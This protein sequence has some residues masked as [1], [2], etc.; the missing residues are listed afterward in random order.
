MSA[1]GDMDIEQ[2][3]LSPEAAK[4]QVS[5]ITSSGYDFLP[6]AATIENLN[7]NTLLKYLSLNQRFYREVILKRLVFS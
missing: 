1:P 5:Q 2:G 6:S 4:K 3:I 7:I